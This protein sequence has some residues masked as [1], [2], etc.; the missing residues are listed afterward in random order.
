[1]DRIEGPEMNPCTY[2]NPVYDRRQEYKL[3]E[4]KSS[5]S[6]TGK[7]GELCVNEWN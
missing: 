1:M 5:V 2:R 7:T 3:E 4:G 6:S